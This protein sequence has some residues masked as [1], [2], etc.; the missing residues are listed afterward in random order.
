VNS[1]IITGA[2]TC[3]ETNEKK[4]L[5]KEDGKGAKENRAGLKRE[6]GVYR[7]VKCS[8]RRGKA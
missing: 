3:Q 6:I 1:L 7:K 5:R 4:E 8:V 2:N